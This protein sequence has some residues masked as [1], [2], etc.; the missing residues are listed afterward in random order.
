MA[1]QPA[2][3]GSG[4]LLTSL[5]VRTTVLDSYGIFRVIA[6]ACRCLP[7]ARLGAAHGA[8]DGARLRAS[9]VTLF[10]LRLLGCI[11]KKTSR[12][13]GNDGTPSSSAVIDCTLHSV[14]SDARMEQL[15]ADA[16]AAPSASAPN[17]TVMDIASSPKRPRDPSRTV[18]ILLTRTLE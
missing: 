12:V 10:F 5:P 15:P 8:G 6:C 4:Q 3:P 7:L 2:A 16:R 14:M 11:R 17:D 18:F 13:E 9:G 1:T